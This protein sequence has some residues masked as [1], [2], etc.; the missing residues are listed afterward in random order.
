M[1]TAMS[2][3]ELFTSGSS[4][5]CMISETSRDTASGPCLAAM[6]VSVSTEAD[7][8][9][10]SLLMMPCTRDP[11]CSGDWV[12]FRSLASRSWILLSPSL[13]LSMASVFCSPLRSS[14]DSLM[15]TDDFASYRAFLTIGLVIREKRLSGF[16]DSI[17]LANASAPSLPTATG[18]FCTSSSLSICSAIFSLTACRL[19]GETRLDLLMTSEKSLSHSSMSPSLLNA[20]RRIV[21]SCAFT[22][23]TKCAPRER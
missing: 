23:T 2:V 22:R 9:C 20:D 11:I 21:P 4:V 13:S 3:T 7:R 8:F 12:S 19:S 18:V 17:I 1:D 15:L 6:P 14:A 16:K 5:D 10:P